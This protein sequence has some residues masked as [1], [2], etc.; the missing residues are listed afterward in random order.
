MP[1]FHFH[2]MVLCKVQYDLGLEDSHR[3]G[4][5]QQILADG[6]CGGLFKACSQ[7]GLLEFGVHENVFGSIDDD[8]LCE[9]VVHQIGGRLSWMQLAS[10]EATT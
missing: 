6:E 8:N 7:Q 1:K 3:D 4:I 5:G 10:R 2:R 9:V